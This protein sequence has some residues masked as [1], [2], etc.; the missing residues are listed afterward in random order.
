MSLI[1][2]FVGVP[3][4]FID[5]KHKSG[6]HELAYVVI[7]QNYLSNYIILSYLLKYP[8]LT[9]KFTNIPVQI[10]ILRLVES[11][12]HKGVN[13]INVLDKIKVSEYSVKDFKDHLY[14]NGPYY[15]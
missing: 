13:G 15:N 12:L 11:K 1:S 10:K 3:I 8:L 7:T 14:L 2:N 5:R 9:Y 6:Q 4:G